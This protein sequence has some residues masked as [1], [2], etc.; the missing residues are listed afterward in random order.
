MKIRNGFVSNSSSSSFILRKLPE[1]VKDCL[2]VYEFYGMD[3]GSDSYEA[4]AFCDLIL[5]SF[6]NPDYQED[7]FINEYFVNNNLDK[8]LHYYDYCFKGSYGKEE[9]DKILEHPEDYFEISVD[10]TYLSGPGCAIGGSY[11]TKNGIEI[12]CH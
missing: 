7:Y 1:N 2:G 11:I 9:L 4:L 8:F 6:K 3:K 10:D 5:K 12:N